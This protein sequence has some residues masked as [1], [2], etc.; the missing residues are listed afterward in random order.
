M[1][2]LREDV[3]GL[4]F[5]VENDPARLLANEMSRVFSALAPMQQ[6]L[7]QSVGGLF[8]N[9]GLGA[10]APLQIP[11]IDLSGFESSLSQ[12][13][14]LIGQFQQVSALAMS[15]LQQKIFEGV[16]SVQT[17]HTVVSTTFW[18]MAQAMYTSLQSVQ[19]NAIGSQIM[20]GL[21]AGILSQKKTIISSVS[22][23]A[24]SIKD[25]I[26]SAMRIASPSKE[27]AKLG[28]F[29][30]LGLPEGFHVAMPE[31]ER[32]SAQLQQAIRAPFDNAQQTTHSA[33]TL[34]PTVSRSSVVSQSQYAPQFSLHLTHNTTTNDR[35]LAQKVR[36]WVRKSFEEVLSAH[37]A[38]VQWE[39]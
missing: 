32:E 29:I 9:S 30:A 1:A 12:A 11:R 28:R 4:R 19:L 13:N 17:M 22:A 10:M 37:D 33:P 23:I 26:S 5:E 18:N 24:Q 31:I 34:A 16:F 20:Q 14:T 6:Q 27:M 39:V 38:T 36:T 21:H 8:Q 2:M 7:T 3:V 35:E 25:T 15:T